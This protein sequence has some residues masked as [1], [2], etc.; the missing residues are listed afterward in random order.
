MRETELAGVDLN[1]LVALS[2]LLAERHVT[3][4]ARRLHQS[5]PVMSRA[6]AELRELFG[7]PL[8]V[9]EGHALRLTARA[10]ALVGPLDRVLAEVRALVAPLSFDPAAA[11]GV[12]RIAAP[13]I[14][15]YMIGPALLRRLARDAPG[16]DLEIGQWT[17]RWREQLA[18]GETDL[19]IAQPDGTEPGLYS[20]VLARNEW[21][22]VLRAGH[23]ALDEPWTV[24]RYAG[25]RHL[26]IGF[27]SS[28]GGQ[29]DDAL[30]A[31]GLT[32]RVALRMPYVVLSPLV[33]AET[34][35]VLTTARWLADKLAR[36]TG[37][38]VRDPPVPLA[39]VD[40]PMIWPERAHGDP[41]HRWFRSVLVEVAD[42]EGIRPSAARMAAI[43]TPDS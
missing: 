30:A 4:A 23:P 11:T 39:P 32:R 1:L 9:R 21:A 26:L 33:V 27:T 17:V 40:L 22:C 41:R 13:D 25:L 3:R 29:V 5:Q 37:L 16:L 2:A 34:D 18:S 42:Q 7:D 10:E 31:V 36:G 6:L 19:T 28:G 38:V 8:L 24:E 12:V 14:V 35:L 20:Q 15:T 43:P